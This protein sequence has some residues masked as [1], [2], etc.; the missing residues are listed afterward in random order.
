MKI[1]NGGKKDYYDYLPGIYGIDEDIVYDRR[2]GYVFRQFSAGDEFFVKDKRYNDR[3]KMPVKGIYYEGNKPQ[4]GIINSGIIMYIVIEVGFT[5]YLFKLER[6]IDDDYEGICLEPT[7]VEKFTVK[8]KKSKA[9]VSVIPVEYGGWY[10]EEAKIRHY[11][12][13]KEII[14]PIFNNTWVTS[15]IPA[16]EMYNEIYNYLISIRE[17]KIEDNRN[18]IQ[19]LESKGFDKKTSFRN[20]INKRKK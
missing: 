17:P 7:L 20:P 2:D 3:S 15:L 13:D 12:L 4:Y 19:K 1:L 14:N 6:Y 9:P 8:D 11:S 16:D 18:D 5:Q 10:K